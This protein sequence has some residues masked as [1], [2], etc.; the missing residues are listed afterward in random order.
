MDRAFVI[1]NTARY[2]SI[3]VHGDIDEASVAGFRIACTSALPVVVDLLRC[4]YIDSSG[5]NALI[6]QNRRDNLALVL[7]PDCRIYRI[8]EIT[9]LLEH[10]L[11]A[12]TPS[13][14]ISLLVRST[15]SKL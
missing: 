3:T 15:D 7:T 2:R 9:K 10:F 13:Q 5:L 14:A 6:A 11:I 12:A 4:P 8:F 1:V